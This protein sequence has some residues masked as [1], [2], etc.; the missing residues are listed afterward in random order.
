MTLDKM[1]IL[2]K[3][4]ELRK[5]LGEDEKSP[6]N[7]FALTAT[8][9]DLT[10]VRYPMSESLSGMCIKS[11]GV[12]LIAIN[13]TRT[14][15]RQCFSLAHELY[16]LFY[17]ENPTAICSSSIGSGSI[18][19]KSADLFASYFLIP[20]LSL[21]TDIEELLKKKT[22]R[23]ISVE[24]VVFLEQKYCVSRLAILVRLK[25]EGSID[26][27]EAETMRSN[28]IIS[29]RNLGYDTDLYRPSTERAQYKTYGQLIKLADKA[30]S[31]G[32]ISNGKYE[33]I[34]LQA[35]RPDIV[36]GEE[37]GGESFD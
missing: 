33:E 21:K 4:Q 27:N 29:A 11:D 17:D 13:S 8:I 7:I 24:D 34:M 15:G 35:F 20:P 14:L 9:D 2:L 23:K 5:K 22:I 26:E 10:L 16:H 18:I 3:S 12:R 19:E 25:D 28:V 1:G 32:L 37:I 30:L 36:Y 31:K 6:V